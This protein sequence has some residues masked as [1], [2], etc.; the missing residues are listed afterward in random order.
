MRLNNGHA[1]SFGKCD[2]VRSR[3]HMYTLIRVDV[4][5]CDM[6]RL[7]I[8]GRLLAMLCQ[9]GRQEYKWA[10]SARRAAQ[11]KL[12][13]KGRTK[14]GDELYGRTKALTVNRID[15]MIIIGKDI[16]HMW[17]LRFSGYIWC[18]HTRKQ[19]QEREIERNTKS[20]LNW[21]RQYHIQAY[22]SVMN[23]RIFVIGRWEKAQWPMASICRPYKTLHVSA[24][25]RTTRHRIKFSFSF[26]LCQKLNSANAQAIDAVVVV[27]TR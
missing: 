23:T 24:R 3:V 26:L 17:W 21:V 4:L 14:R 5:L 1:K 9:N 10:N 2:L 25:A 27:H 19:K 6:Q 15:R 16:R 12:A 11:L 22:Y 20:R 8:D 18:A 7:V 13:G